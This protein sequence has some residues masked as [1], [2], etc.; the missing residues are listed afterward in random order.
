MKTSSSRIEMLDRIKH[1][2]MAYILVIKFLDENTN[3]SSQ[4]PR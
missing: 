2:W 1:Y 3:T 4:I